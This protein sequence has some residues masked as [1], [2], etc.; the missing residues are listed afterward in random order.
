ML[1]PQAVPLKTPYIN[2]VPLKEEPPEELDF[3]F[4]LK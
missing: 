4:I 3:I 1:L 2:K